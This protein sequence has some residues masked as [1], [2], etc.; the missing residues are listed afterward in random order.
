MV[1]FYQLL[2]GEILTQHFT[3]RDDVELETIRTHIQRRLQEIAIDDA[4]GSSD[5]VCL[6]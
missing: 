3:R 6:L 5:T 2:S 4:D 1:F